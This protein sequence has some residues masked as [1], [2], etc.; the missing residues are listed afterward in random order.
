MSASALDDG[1]AINS[2]DIDQLAASAILLEENGDFNG[3]IALYKIGI[4]LGDVTC[5][6]RLADLMSEPPQFKNVP[7]AEELY[8]RACIAG[9]ASG[10]RNL[11]ILYRQLGRSD[12]HERYM[13]YAKTRGDRW[14]TDD[15]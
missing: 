11:A 13:A 15:L 8:K 12:L 9:D 10:C 6:V 5:M 7:L 14:Q 1:T 4:S 2:S 3:A